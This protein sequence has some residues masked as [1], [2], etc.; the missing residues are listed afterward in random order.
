[1]VTSEEIVVDSSLSNSLESTQ[2]TSIAAPDEEVK[3]Y[4]KK[5]STRLWGGLSKYFL[6]IA[7][8]GVIIKHGTC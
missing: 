6:I 1:M 3:S 7:I 4:S 8:I 5:P 2:A